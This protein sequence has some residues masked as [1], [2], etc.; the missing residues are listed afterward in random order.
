MDPQINPEPQI[1][2]KIPYSKRT[3]NPKL[4]KPIPQLSEVDYN[5]VIDG[6]QAKT[7]PFSTRDIIWVNYQVIRQLF[8]LIFLSFSY[9]NSARQISVIKLCR[10]PML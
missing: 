5:V 6:V 4:Y 7:S 2:L 8:Q 1:W 10:E 9:L 3:Q